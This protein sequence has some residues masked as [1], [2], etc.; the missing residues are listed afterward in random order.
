MSEL[1]VLDIIKR[2]TYDMDA[3]NPPLPRDIEKYVIAYSMCKSPE[4]GYQLACQNNHDAIASYFWDLIKGCVPKELCYLLLLKHWAETNDKRFDLDAVRCLVG[5]DCF[6]TEE[7]VIRLISETVI[8]AGQHLWA[9]KVSS[10]TGFT[11]NNHI[12]DRGCLY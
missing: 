4:L 11:R 9:L 10:F 6:G 5:G 8:N 12:F 2:G 7:L 1:A 3:F